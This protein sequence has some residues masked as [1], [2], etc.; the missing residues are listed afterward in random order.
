VCVCVCVLR[1]AVQC[2]ANGGRWM[3]ATL[4]WYGLKLTTLCLL[5]PA[6]DEIVPVSSSFSSCARPVTAACSCVAADGRWL[7]PMPQACKLS[8]SFAPLS[9]TSCIKFKIAQAWSCSSCRQNFPLV[10][11]LFLGLWWI[12][13]TLFA[14]SVVSVASVCFSLL[15]G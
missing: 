4:R 15:F 6:V 1:N 3:P 11:Y 5:A 9:A 10:A 12:L 14:V 13:P 8:A 7:L 2:C